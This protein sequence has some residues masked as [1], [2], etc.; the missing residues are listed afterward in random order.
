MF[1]D[2]GLWRMA[3]QAVINLPIKRDETP[4]AQMPEM[5]V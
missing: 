2:A 4:K 3:K 5:V 1:A